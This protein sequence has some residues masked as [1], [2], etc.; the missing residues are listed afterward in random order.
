MRAMPSTSPFLAVPAS[1]MASVAACMSMRPPATAVRWV[2]ALVATSTMWAWPCASKWV[3]VFIAVVAC[4][5]V[6][7]TQAAG[8]ADASGYAHFTN[9]LPGCCIIRPCVCHFASITPCR[10]RLCRSC[11]G[12]CVLACSCFKWPSCRHRPRRVPAHRRLRARLPTSCRAWA[13]PA[14]SRP[15]PNADWGTASR[16]KY[17]ATRT[18]STIR[19]WVTMWMRS[20]SHCSRRHAAGARCP[21]NSSSVSPGRS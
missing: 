16:A 10:H 18:T 15:A 13:T 4:E 14:N 21:T 7:F 3:R 11:C 2:L 6:W 8:V 1:M 12:T 19:C 20:G 5:G 17:S 9:H